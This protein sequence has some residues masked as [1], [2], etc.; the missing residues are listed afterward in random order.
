MTEKRG[1]RRV[2]AIRLVAVREILQL[3]NDMGLYLYEKNSPLFLLVNWNGVERYD[4]RHWLEDGTPG[5]GI[6]FTKEEM[7]KLF[8]SLDGFDFSEKYEKPIRVYNSGKMRALFYRLISS[9]SISYFSETTWNK[10]VNVL[11]WGYG[12]KVDFRKWSEDYDK[13]GKGISISFDELKEF[14]RLILTVI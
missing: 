8:Y 14:K 7:E 9:L 11:D 6:T 5:K 10:E 4:L 13:C 2:L 3:K 1:M 12:I